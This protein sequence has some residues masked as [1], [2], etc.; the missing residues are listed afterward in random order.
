VPTVIAVT[1]AGPPDRPSDAWR[2]VEAGS[3]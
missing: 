1:Y 3:P 2:I